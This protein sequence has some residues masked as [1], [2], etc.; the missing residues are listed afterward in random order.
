MQCIAF[1]APMLPGKTETDRV[2]M[3]SCS[4]GERKADHEASR[5]RHGISREA[6]WVQQTPAGDVAVVY[7]EA[8][9]LQ[10][11]FAGLG[12]SQ[13]PFDR[14]FRDLVRDVHGIDLAQGFPP[15]EQLVDFRR[16]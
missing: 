8:D 14:W 12:S 2:A 7:L 3:L 5:A 1:A 13:E 6:V 9:D 4:Q 10:A 11:A 16:G 15:P